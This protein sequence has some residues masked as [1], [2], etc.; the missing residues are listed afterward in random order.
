MFW[1]LL[2]LNKPLLYCIV[3]LK[4]VGFFT[5]YVPFLL[6]DR[7]IYVND[8]RKV[9]KNI[10]FDWNQGANMA[11]THGCHLFISSYF[12]VVFAQ[13][14]G[15]PEV[16]LAAKDIQNIGFKAR[17]YTAEDSYFVSF[18]LKDRVRRPIVVFGRNRFT[19]LDAP[20][21]SILLDITVYSTIYER[22][23]STGHH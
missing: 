15:I 16:D 6:I 12:L 5:V 21:H 13:M 18:S 23:S 10:N 1:L 20:E 2:I 3:L 22:T 4:D 9:M 14:H 19:F 7:F 17:S 8:L 11:V